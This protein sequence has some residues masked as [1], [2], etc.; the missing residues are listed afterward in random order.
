MLSPGIAVMKALRLTRDQ[1]ATVVRRQHFPQLIAGRPRK[2]EQRRTSVGEPSGAS[3]NTTRAVLSCVG[4]RRR[5][6]MVIGP[7]PR[8]RN[9]YP[10]RSTMIA[11]KITTW[12][13][14][15]F[16]SNGAPTTSPPGIEFMI[17]T[18]RHLR[19]TWRAVPTRRCGRADADGSFSVLGSLQR[20]RVSDGKDPHDCEPTALARPLQTGLPRCRAVQAAHSSAASTRSQ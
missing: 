4:H 11:R 1:A 16:T 12:A 13:T 19:S 5:E 15:P 7:R 6:R 2:S 18:S 17:R 9:A 20:Q 3:S 14:G 8:I 10:T